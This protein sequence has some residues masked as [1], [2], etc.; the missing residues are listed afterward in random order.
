[1]ALA[2][3]GEQREDLE[4]LAGTLGISEHVSFLGVRND[5]PDLLSAAD[6]VLMP[7]LTEGF[8]RVAIEAMAAGKSVI[9][10][11][12]GG[13]PEAITHGQSGILVQPKNIESMSTA[14]VELV[15]D[16]EL[17]ARLSVAA[18]KHVEQNYSVEK[19]VARLDEIYSQLS[20]VS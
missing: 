2:G 20:S 15:R 19:Y 3:E 14:L 9:A 5:L 13:V 6:S 17:Q 8:P 12:V 18:R 11:K 16:V 10:T 4:A 1:M 7:S